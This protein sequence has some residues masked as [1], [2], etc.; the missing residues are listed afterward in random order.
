MTFRRG[1]FRDFYQFGI[2]AFGLFHIY[3]HPHILFSLLQLS[4][5][6]EVKED[7]RS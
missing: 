7:M 6:R 4:S 2:L 5:I 3:G 1:V